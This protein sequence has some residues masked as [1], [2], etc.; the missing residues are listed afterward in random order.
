MDEI[1]AETTFEALAQVTAKEYIGKMEGLESI[2]LQLAKLQQIVYDPKTKSSKYL[3]TQ[4]LHE[5]FQSVLA[6]ID[7]GDPEEGS[8]IPSISYMFFDALSHRLKTNVEASLPDRN[9]TDFQTNLNR[10]HI[11]RAEVEKEE[12]KI[13]LFVNI[14]RSVQSKQ[15]GEPPSWNRGD[16]NT[17]RTFMAGHNTGDSGDEDEREGYEDD[18]GDNTVTMPSM[19]FL[20]GK[21]KNEKNTA[22][23]MKG[24]ITCLSVAETALREASGTRGPIKCWGCQDVEE[25]QHDCFHRWIHCP[26]K[27]RHCTHFSSI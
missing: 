3:P 17:P 8:D 22:K 24:L 1:R 10:Y 27:Q 9:A 25:Y 26:R 4:Q 23:L 14:A 15:R 16:R 11:F 7:G 2:T 6:E 20:A 21:D 18:E 12:E 13:R 5:Q 19:T